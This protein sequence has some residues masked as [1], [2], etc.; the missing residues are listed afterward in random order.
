M[1]LVGCD[2][3]RKCPVLLRASAVNPGFSD[4]T[5]FSDAA[6]FY[7]KR[8]HLVDAP[9]S[10]GGGTLCFKPREREREVW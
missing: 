1:T 5:R 10:D 3:V 8:S 2:S 9:F 4:S 6:A 7:K